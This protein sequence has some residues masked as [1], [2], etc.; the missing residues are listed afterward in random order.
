MYE[1]PDYK[2]KY[3][4]CD[5]TGQRICEFFDDLWVRTDGYVKK[6][7]G[8][9]GTTGK[10]YRGNLDSYGY[11]NI[12][13]KKLSSS[14]HRMVGIAFLE[15]LHPSYIQI[16]HINGKRG[17]NRIENL[18]WCSISDNQ[19]NRKTHR[20]GKLAGASYIKSLGKWCSQINV[21]GQY[22]FLGY[23]ATELEAHTVYL[24]Y[25]NSNIDKMR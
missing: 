12:G 22:I 8:R 2:G 24:E 18:R 9:K 13:R 25:R 5:I 7:S 6:L 21:N 1:N 23:Y 4:I 16:D 11:Y 3:S 10:W 15:V 19:I 17:D 20:N 14:V